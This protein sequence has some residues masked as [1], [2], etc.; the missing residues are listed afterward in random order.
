LHGFDLGSSAVG[1]Q[2]GEHEVYFTS[3]GRFAYETNCN[4]IDTSRRSTSY[5]YRLIKY[6]TRGFS[7]IA[8]KLDLKQLKSD[9]QEISLPI[10]RF[11]YNSINES[12]IVVSMYHVTSSSAEE[13]DYALVDYPDPE[14]WQLRSSLKHLVDDLRNQRRTT[15]FLTY[16]CQKPYKLDGCKP[17][18]S[19]KQVEA[20]YKK[21]RN[22]CSTT[23]I[24]DLMNYYINPVKLLELMTFGENKTD[25]LDAEIKNQYD[26]IIERVKQVMD[27][28]YP[29]EWITTNP[30]TQLS[31]SFNPIMEDES[32]WYGNYYSKQ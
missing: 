1:Y 20:F 5:E 23:K 11:R 28:T 27:S 17:F 13:S 32:Q 12:N 9:N 30:G 16:S 3:L 2:P 4:I 7:I 10:M 22:I 31:S 8:P 29:V 26:Q 14:G 25:L 24:G 18:L 6:L 21:N 19:V 15:S